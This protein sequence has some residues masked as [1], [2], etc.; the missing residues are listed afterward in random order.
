MAVLEISGFWGAF[1]RIGFSGIV[2]EKESLGKSLSAIEGVGVGEAIAARAASK[3]RSMSV[4]SLSGRGVARGGVE[5]FGV[6]GMMDFAGSGV[7]VDFEAGRAGV[8][9]IME[10][11]GRA[12]AVGV[13][14]RSWRLGGGAAG[15]CA[16]F[17]TMVAAGMSGL[18]SGAG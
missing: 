7:V 6:A 11:A 17:G 5:V 13:A 15:F 14:G 8:A 1:S 10:V 3:P 2:L 9:G 12:G 18:R 4:L 16:T